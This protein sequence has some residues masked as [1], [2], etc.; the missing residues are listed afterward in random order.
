M[1]DHITYWA[2]DAVY[3]CPLEYHAQTCTGDLITISVR[4][5][6]CNRR[7]L[8]NAEYADDPAVATCIG[9]RDTH[10]RV[11]LF[12]AETEKE[13]NVVIEKISGCDLI[14]EEEHI[15]LMNAA[16]FGEIMPRDPLPDPNPKQPPED[17]P[18]ANNYSNISPVGHKEIANHDNVQGSAVL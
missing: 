2:A 10:F 7:R 17:K 9:L 4:I 3:P 16:M 11:M 18:R 1:S 15:A 8:V 5:S 13:I 12:S 6:E 14:F